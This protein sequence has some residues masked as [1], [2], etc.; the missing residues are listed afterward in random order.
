MNVCTPHPETI[1]PVSFGERGMTL[2]AGNH[3]SLAYIGPGPVSQA[4]T[5][6]LPEGH[7]FFYRVLWSFVLSIDRASQ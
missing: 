2:T 5:P 4:S 3:A 6:P 7:D 1:D